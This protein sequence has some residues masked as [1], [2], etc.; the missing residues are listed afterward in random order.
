[1]TQSN[2]CLQYLGR[3][4]KM[5]GSNALE[6]SQCEQL[7]CECMDLRNSVTD[8]AY[9]KVSQ[10]PAD[11]LKSIESNK[12]GPMAKLHLWKSTIGSTSPAHFIGSSACAADFHI[13]EIV[14]QILS[15]AKFHSVYETFATTFP[16]LLQVRSVCYIYRLL[17][18]CMCCNSSTQR[19]PLSRRTA[20]TCPLHWPPCPRTTSWPPSGPPRA[21]RSSSQVRSA[22]GGDPR[23]STRL[24]GA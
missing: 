18:L 10:S 22:H 13:W 23:G 1:M 21:A 11:F 5:M 7:L 8:F 4:L 3:K 12:N 9:G 24:A 15:C 14:D 20:S 2:A 17:S 6:E 19:S 16:A